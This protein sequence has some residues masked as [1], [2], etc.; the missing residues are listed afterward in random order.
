MGRFQK[1]SDPRGTEGKASRKNSEANRDNLFPVK[2]EIDPGSPGF[3]RFPQ[4]PPH[5]PES[6]RLEV[7]GRSK[8]D[9]LRGSASAWRKVGVICLVI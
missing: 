3:P 5:K 1:T 4:L 2:I 8:V 9:F 6:D 7:T